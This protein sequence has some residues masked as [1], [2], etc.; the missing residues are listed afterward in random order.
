MYFCESSIRLLTDTVVYILT[1]ISG[2]VNRWTSSINS[3][4]V[5][6]PSK[7]VLEDAL[8]KL[9][10]KHLM[11]L[12]AYPRGTDSWIS[13]PQMQCSWV[14]SHT[15]VW[16]Q[17]PPPTARQGGNPGSQLNTA[18]KSFIWRSSQGT[19]CF[20]QQLLWGGQVPPEPC[21][22]YNKS[23]DCQILAGNYKLSPISCRDFTLAIPLSS[24]SV[25]MSGLWDH[26]LRQGKKEKALSLTLPPACSLYQQTSWTQS[27]CS[28]LDIQM[29]SPL[30]LGTESPT[31]LL[32][33]K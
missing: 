13:S 28:K 26:Y 16:H 1:I 33:Y 29:N 19:H 30:F 32:N 22:A 9:S 5:Q 11:L 12:K 8:E 6:L 24:V 23:E 14:S 2:V 4:K 7:V 3:A 10:P 17:K 21:E 31:A 15:A 27:K 20:S 25:H 18:P